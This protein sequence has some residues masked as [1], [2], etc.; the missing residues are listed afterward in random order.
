MIPVDDFNF[1]YA[2]TYSYNKSQEEVDFDSDLSELTDLA[3][4]SG[5]INIVFYERKDGFWVE[6]DARKEMAESQKRREQE[7][8]DDSRKLAEWKV[9]VFGPKNLGAWWSMHYTE[10]D[11]LKTA[12]KLPVEMRATVTKENS[13]CYQD[14]ENPPALENITKFKTVFN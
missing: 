4:L 9:W 1:R 11:A 13:R 8:K 7:K 6:I 12:S 5:Y 3:Y 10:E 14:W 2:M